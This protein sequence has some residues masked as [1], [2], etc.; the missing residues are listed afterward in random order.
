MS[1]MNDINDAKKS[2]E[3]KYRIIKAFSFE[4]DPGAYR[5]KCGS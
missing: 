3:E 1:Q 2:V 4:K 5:T